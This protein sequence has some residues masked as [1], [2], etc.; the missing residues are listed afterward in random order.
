MTDLL[1]NID[2]GALE[3]ELTD[4]VVDSLE[5]VIDA[6][7]VDLQKFGLA[8][9]KNLVAVIREDRPDLLRSLKGQVR[10][11]AEV[12]RVRLNRE[13]RALLSRVLDVAVRVGKV[14][15]TAAVAAV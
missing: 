4:L 13:A 12:N 11:L 5:E 6:A 3:L 9:A 14:I 15:L 1:D 8:I 2:F 7:Q 10:M